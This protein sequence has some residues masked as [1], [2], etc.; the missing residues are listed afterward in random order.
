M[1]LECKVDKIFK[2]LHP[3]EDLSMCANVMS[4]FIQELV[5]SLVLGEIPPKSFLIPRPGLVDVRKKCILLL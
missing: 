1:Q 3:E 2:I 4:V 5:T